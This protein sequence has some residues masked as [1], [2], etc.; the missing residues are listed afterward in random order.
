ML[1]ALLT[2]AA[3]AVTQAP[4]RSAVT[5]SRDVAPILFQNCGICHHPGGPAPFSLLTYPDARQHATQIAAATKSR[6]MPPWKSQPGLV[7]FVGQRHLTNEEIGTIEK[8]VAGGTLEGEGA[9]AAPEWTEGWQLGKPDLVVSLPQ[10]YTLPAEGVDVSRVFVLPVPLNAMRYV[11]GLEFRPGNSRVVHHANIRIDRTRASRR[12]DEA[13]PV[14]GYDGLILRSATFPDG[15][16]LGWTPGQISPLLPKGLAWRLDSGADLVVEIHMQ[17]SGRPEAVNPA[18]GL[19]FTDDPPAR[20]PVM[21]RLGRQNIDI[22][23]GDSHYVEEDSFV[24][25]VDVDLQALQPHAHHRAREVT[26]LA[27][28]PDGTSR[29][30]IKIDAWDFRWQHVYR[31]ASPMFL[32]RGTTI[33]MR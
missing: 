17:P 24:L 25:P 20:T 13:D 3:D 23:P 9:P 14:P 18:I 22:A 2:A 21:L 11:K 12:L 4:Q 6:Y 10:P 32:P 15:Y 29:W 1:A 28:F 7:Q 16:F 19:Y 27:T 5:F 30:L 8:W 33:S 26:G 31:L